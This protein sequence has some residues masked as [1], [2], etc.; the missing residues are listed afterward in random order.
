MV[1]RALSQQ[2]RPRLSIHGKPVRE[3]PWFYGRSRKN[4][5]PI[6]KKAGFYGRLKETC[7]NRPS[8]DAIVLQNQKKNR[9]SLKI[10]DLRLKYP[11][12]GSGNFNQSRLGLDSGK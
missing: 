11:E 2:N 1:S 5:R 12:P 10:K 4:D 7:S 9:K 3:I 6:R 8:G